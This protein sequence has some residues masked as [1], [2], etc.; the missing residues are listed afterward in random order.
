MPQQKI[1]GQS[2][3]RGEVHRYSSILT[4]SSAMET[5]PVPAQS[6]PARR[7]PA[8]TNSALVKHVSA[9]FR[10]RTSYF[11]AKCLN[12][13]L[14]S[15]SYARAT[16]PMRKRCSG[17]S[18]TAR[19]QRSH[20]NPTKGPHTSQESG[21]TLTELT[22]SATKSATIASKIC[23]TYNSHTLPYAPAQHQLQL[24]QTHR[25]SFPLFRQ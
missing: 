2:R 12:M 8:N 5:E 14:G 13:R 19:L 16:K 15:S 10:K 6:V 24:F 1:E 22:T 17:D 11:R 20:K 4:T 21:N 9:A 3:K 18:V 23:M 25:P 7:Q